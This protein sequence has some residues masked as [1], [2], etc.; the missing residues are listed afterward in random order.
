MSSNARPPR[1]ATR[2]ADSGMAFVLALFALTTIAMAATSALLVASSDIRAT[3]NYREASQVHFVAESAIAHA[4][5]VVNGPGVVNFQNDVVTPWGTLFGTGARTFAPVGGYTYTVSSSID[6][7]DVVN[8]GRFVA[9]A[10]GPE[11]TRNVVVA[12]VTRSNI[13]STAPGAIYLSQDGQTNATFNGTGFLVDGNDHNYTGGLASPNNPVPGISTRNATNT[14]EAIT[15]LSTN[16][17]NDVTGLGYIAGSPSVP[18]VLTSPAAPSVAQ[19]DQLA[20]DLL[21]RPGVVNVSDTQVHG[22]ATFGTEAQPQI[23]YFSN[24]NGVTI[25]ANGNSSGAGV[26][27]VEGDL[28]IQGSIDFKGLIIV[29]GRT[30]VIGT[31][32]DTGNATVYG[33]LWTN[34]LNLTV[35]GSALLYYS[36]QALSLANQVS[37]GTALPAPVVVS[38]LIDCSQAVAGTGG[39]P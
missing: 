2:P 21:A 6:P 25:K 19:L 18:S 10:T 17:R 11:G 31:T 37:G 5:Q 39:C 3:R 38:S 26:M 27:I 14:Q 33:S 13:P 8:A 35:G 1:R 9:T 16:Q 23:T 12:R 36:S 4:M 15:S 7:A 22:N 20:A 28:T 34:D 29:R 32:D 24:P 30:Q